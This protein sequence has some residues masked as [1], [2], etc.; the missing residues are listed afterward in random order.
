MKRSDLKKIIREE[1][2]NTLSET[3]I[4]DK[5]T[6]INKVNDIAR[7]DKK[8]PNTVRTA[9]TQAKTSGKPITI[10]EDDEDD[11][12]SQNT[13]KV[14][15]DLY[16]KQADKESKEEEKKDIKS[17]LKGVKEDI[18]KVTSLS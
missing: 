8:D 9:I 7:Q 2:I 18:D 16:D 15:K 5:A 6:D 4:V 13:E 3:T 17:L 1:I 11:E 10:A 12:I 14:A